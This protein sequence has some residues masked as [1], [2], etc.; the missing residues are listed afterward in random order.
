MEC[1]SQLE[2]K[3]HTLTQGFEIARLNTLLQCVLSKMHLTRHELI[4]MLVA[5]SVSTRRLELEEGLEQVQRALR[6]KLGAS[7]V[8]SRRGWSC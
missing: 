6:L 8:R 2:I 7:E 5:Y 1:E 3:R 4:Q